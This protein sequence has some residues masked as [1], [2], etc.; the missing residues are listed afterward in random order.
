M[1]WVP[2]GRWDTMRWRSG[3]PGQ[4]QIHPRKTSHDALSS[5]TDQP[6]RS[7][8]IEH[9][10]SEISV[11]HEVV[12][13]VTHSCMSWHWRSNSHPVDMWTLR[14]LR[15][16]CRWRQTARWCTQPSAPFPRSCH[17]FCTQR[18]RRLEL[19]TLKRFHSV[20]WKSLRIVEIISPFTSCLSSST[21]RLSSS[22][23]IKQLCTFEVFLAKRKLNVRQLT[24]DFL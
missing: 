20:V 9:C 18:M 17:R 3:Y 13:S 15:H 2:V 23:R 14:M 4:R 8:A 1:L 21:S 5:R 6:L 16:N 19:A 7:P 12:L 11:L 22:V 10:A 24:D